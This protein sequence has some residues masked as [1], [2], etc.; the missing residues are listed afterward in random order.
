ME[1][2]EAQENDSKRKYPNTS[3][4]SFSRKQS[5]ELN[6]LLLQS[7]LPQPLTEKEREVLV[8]YLL[9]PNQDDLFCHSN[10]TFVK[11]AAKFKTMEVLNEYNR[12]LRNKQVFIPKGSKWIINPILNIPS[13]TTKYNLNVEWVIRNDS[14]Q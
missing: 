13:G 12:K 8:Q 2:L 7:F 14:T 11:Q 10:K 6:I 4:V 9:S 5:F 3:E 1:A